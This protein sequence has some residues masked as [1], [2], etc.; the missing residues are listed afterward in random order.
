MT[1]FFSTQV[2]F[3]TGVMVVGYQVIIQALQAPTGCTG[4]A[5]ALNQDVFLHN[6]LSNHYS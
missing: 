3:A 6:R 2:S 5:H 4:T 1:F